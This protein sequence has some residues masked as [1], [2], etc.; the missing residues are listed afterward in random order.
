MKSINLSE[1]WMEEPPPRVYETHL[2][3]LEADEVV[4]LLTGG[5]LFSRQFRVL[6]IFPHNV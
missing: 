6:L 2:V 3:G 1:P 5:R 4:I